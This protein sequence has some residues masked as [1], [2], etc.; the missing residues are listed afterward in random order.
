MSKHDNL[1]EAAKE[2]VNKVFGDQSVSRATT[3]ESLEEIA[4]DIEILLDSLGSDED[5]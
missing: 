1:V 4:G 2:A 3:R 5:E